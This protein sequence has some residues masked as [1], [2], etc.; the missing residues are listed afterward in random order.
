MNARRS[1]R[2][3]P[4]LHLAGLALVLAFA[5]LVL[6]DAA[7][8]PVTYSLTRVE[9]AR[10]VDFD[11]GVVWILVL[12]SDARP[13][14]Q[15]TEARTDAIQL[16]GIDLQAGRAAGIGIPRDSWVEVPGEGLNRINE[17]MR[18]GEP[19][20]GTD[21]AAKVV[22][23]LV[24]ITPDYVFLAGFDGFKAMVGA[25]GGVGVRAD[26]GF[27]DPEFDLTVKKGRNH[28][29][30]TDALD[31]ARS[32]KKLEAGDFARSANQQRVMLGI[33]GELRAH[34]D[35]DGFMERGTLAALGGLQ[36]SLAPTELYRLAQ[37]V[38]Q[39]DPDRVTTCV[40]G[41]APMTTSAGAQ[42]IE[43]DKA[44]A[45]RLGDAARETARLPRDCA[46]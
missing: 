20:Q 1:T 12:G 21:L 7:V 11:D 17:A 8:H 3:R 43:V 34:E 25:I 39:V 38:T 2:R 15:L 41:G 26:K 24:G 30:G 23:Q 35:E 19:E 28:F 27:H 14:E 22:A 32:R 10:H 5:A 44:Q 40:I 46:V 6:P 29:D 42:V 31:F 45:R 9:T 18:L 37:A 16:V 13:G 33:L 4:R 36:T